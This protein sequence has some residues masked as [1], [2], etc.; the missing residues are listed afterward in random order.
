MRRV[1]AA[2]AA[3]FDAETDPSRRAWIARRRALSSR[4]GR[5]EC[6]LCSVCAYTDDFKFQVVG[7]ERAMRIMCIWHELTTEFNLRMAIPAKREAGSSTL[8]L[9]L[10]G[11]ATLGYEVIPRAKQS[12]AVAMLTD[13]NVDKGM[14]ND[15]YQQLRGLLQHLVPFSLGSTAMYHMHAP[16]T[17]AA[18]LGPTG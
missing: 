13:I 17:R 3:A 8:W 9:G 7:I 4:T 6:R 18:H 16:A 10:R 2:E 12:R 1:D 11:Y 15:E 5:N 14:R